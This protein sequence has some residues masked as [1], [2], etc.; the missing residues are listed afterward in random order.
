V[1][2]EIEEQL[3]ISSSEDIPSVEKGESYSCMNLSV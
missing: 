2:E 1:P 3:G